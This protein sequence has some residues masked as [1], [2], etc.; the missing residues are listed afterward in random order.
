MSSSP[1]A[2][3][4]ERDWTIHSLNIHGI[5]FER[6][7]QQAINSQQDWSLTTT[8][9]PV[10]VGEHES[11]LDIRADLRIGGRRLILLI[12]CKKN[13]PEFIEWVCFPKPAGIGSHVHFPCIETDAGYSVPRKGLRR[14]NLDSQTMRIVSDARETRE[15]YQS[16]KQQNK[17][18]TSNAAITD[19]AMQVALATHSIHAEETRW[20]QDRASN[21][22]R[23]SPPPPPLHPNTVIVPMIVTTARLSVCDF[24]AID[25]NGATG[26][27]SFGD[28][29]LSPVPRVVYEFPLPRYLHTHSPEPES[30]MRRHIV[31]VNSSCFAEFL[32]KHA[33]DLLPQ[34]RK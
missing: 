5:F 30:G 21:P 23:Q 3:Q 9:Y 12:E 15:N 19:A 8:N 24:R 31:I 13:N 4:S 18:K 11:E 32:E 17:T 1:P 25:V 14:V 28:V 20:A 27:I 10:A 22:L 33:I 6:W 29:T 16:H 7:C 26:E 2:P 34:E